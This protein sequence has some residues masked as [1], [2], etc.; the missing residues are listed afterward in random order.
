M[1]QVERLQFKEDKKLFIQ[2]L[3]NRNTDLKNCISYC[4][5]YD[6]SKLNDIKKDI[7]EKN[8]SK[9]FLIGMGSSL[10]ASQYVSERLNKFDV[11]VASVEANEFKENY[12]HLVDE[13]TLLVVI[14]QSGNSKEIVEVI[15]ELKVR[16]TICKLITLTNN[17]EGYLYKNY[18]NSI[19]LNASKEFYI[20]HNSYLNTLLVLNYLFN[21]LF[22]K[23]A[24]I[25]EKNANLL[26]NK[27]DELDQF[28]HDNKTQIMNIVKNIQCVDFIYSLESRHNAMNSTLL[29]REGL[30]MLTGCYSKNEYLHGEHL[31]SKEHKLMCFVGLDSE[32]E[33]YKE[34]MEEIECNLQLL[35]SSC[36][37]TSIVSTDNKVEIKLDKDIK[38]LGE[39]VVFNQIVAWGMEI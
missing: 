5:K 13:Q 29:L 19:L 33:K 16:K 30:E 22:E 3:N 4:E 38:D 31:V 10:Y 28:L 39:M 27:L 23:D 25:L 12:I 34:I 15:E 6:F 37:K 11:F 17:L 24:F 2:E 8:I 1:N 9:I 7:R 32:E 35:V 14:S 18:E 21:Y 36:E 26:I 20:S